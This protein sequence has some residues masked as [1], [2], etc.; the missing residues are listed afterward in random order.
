MLLSCRLAYREVIHVLYAENTFHCS[1]GA[2]LLYTERLLPR[3]RT[4]AITSFVYH[5]RAESLDEYAAEHLGLEKP[6]W[7]AYE[8]LLGRIPVA[9]PSL[10]RL[11]VIFP[12]RAGIGLLKVDEEED[13][14]VVGLNVAGGGHDAMRER[15]TAPMDAI[16]AAF[17]PLLE[18]C[19]LLVDETAFDAHFGRSADDTQDQ[20]QGQMNYLQGWWG[21]GSR[22]PKTRCKW[23][24][25]GDDDS[26]VG[27]AIG[28]GEEGVP[29]TG[30]WIRGVS[31]A[32]N[33]TPEDRWGGFT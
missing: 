16:V 15:I 29:G 14:D 12:C 30:Y 5:A 19:F 17:G 7:S 26:E 20:D 25:L 3:E 11:T 10:R 8:V 4:A 28:V 27:N 31:S 32:E 9:F 33:Y 6:G 18:V 1:T 2:L 24:R 22:P 21:E 23:R 13:G